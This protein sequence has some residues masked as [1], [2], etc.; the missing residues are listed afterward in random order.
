M[1]V[2]VGVILAKPHRD[3]DGDDTIGEQSEHF[4]RRRR[5]GRQ[6]VATFMDEHQQSVVGKAPDEIGKDDH[7]PNGQLPEGKAQRELQQ[8]DCRHVVLRKRIGAGKPPH[9]RILLKNRLLPLTVPVGSSHEIKLI[10][11]HYRLNLFV[12][13]FLVS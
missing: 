4:V 10:L 9:L 3:G 7:H 5:L 8:Y 13:C 6:V 12:L 1:Q 11:C 2:V